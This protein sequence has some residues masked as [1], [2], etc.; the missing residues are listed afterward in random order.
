MPEALGPDV[1]A[2]RGG[3]GECAVFLALSRSY[4]SDVCDTM[5]LFAMVYAMSCFVCR[6]INVSDR[7]STQP[8]RF[9]STATVVIAI[10]WLRSLAHPHGQVRQHFRSCFACMYPNQH[11]MC[12]DV[13]WM[14]RDMAVRADCAHARSP[15]LSVQ[16]LAPSPHAVP[17]LQQQIMDDTLLR[18]YP[19]SL[20][21]GGR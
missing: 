10:R 7:R 11:A 4:G 12:V 6:C 1:I 21:R 17:W 14:C 19:R 20:Q 2:S 3:H 15:P 16:L 8:A 18:V 13:G 5:G 9:V